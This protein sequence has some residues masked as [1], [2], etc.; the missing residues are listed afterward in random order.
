MA[1][2][3]KLKPFIVAELHNVPGVLV[4]YKNGLMNKGLTILLVFF[5]LMNPG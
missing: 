3:K 1:N 5:L 4:A 2:G